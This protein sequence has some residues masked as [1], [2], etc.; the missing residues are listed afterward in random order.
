MQFPFRLWKLSSLIV[1]KPFSI[2][3]FTFYGQLIYPISC[4]FYFNFTPVY[5]AICG[6][7]NPNPLMRTRDPFLWLIS[8]SMWTGLDCPFIYL[9]PTFFCLF[10]PEAGIR[11]EESMIWVMLQMMLRS[12]RLSLKIW[13]AHL[14]IKWLQLYRSEA[15]Y[16]YPGPRNLHS[17]IFGLVLKVYMQNC[18]LLDYYLFSTYFSCFVDT[19]PSYM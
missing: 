13:M 7:L 4:A 2:M 19:V 11:K 16:P 6:M 18:T 12:S 9:F 3:T 10:Q 15:R 8:F 5:G 1:M 14:P 17:W